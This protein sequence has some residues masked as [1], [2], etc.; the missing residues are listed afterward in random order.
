MLKCLK[1]NVVKVPFVS[2]FLHKWSSY[3]A[4]ILKE[5]FFKRIVVVT[6]TKKQHSGPWILGRMRRY[7]LN[8]TYFLLNDSLS[9]KH[10]SNRELIVVNCMTRD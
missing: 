2:V 6:Y 3:L 5:H 10:M 1:M 8:Y 7:F 4:V 9:S